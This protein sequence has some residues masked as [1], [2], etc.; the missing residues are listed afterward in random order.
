M[1]RIVWVGWKE[2]DWVDWEG[3][4]LRMATGM[5]TGCGREIEV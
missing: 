5:D 1:E 2:E 3:M 4:G